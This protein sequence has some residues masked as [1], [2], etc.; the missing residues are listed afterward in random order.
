MGKT[1]GR[2]GFRNPPVGRTLN[3]SRYRRKI[4]VVL[5]NQ[6]AV[7]DVMWVEDENSLRYLGR[8]WRQTSA[9]LWQQDTFG[10]RFNSES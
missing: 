2:I 10:S 4:E 8:R 5:N 7:Y 3:K 1:G 6:L 9:T